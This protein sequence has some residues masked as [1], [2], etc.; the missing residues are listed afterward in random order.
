M[1]PT[2]GTAPDRTALLEI[3][4]R[5]GGLFSAEQALEAGYSPPLIHHHTKRKTFERVRR[6]IYRVVGYPPHEYEEFIAL[7]LWS[8]QS[9]IFSHA[10]ALELHRLSD[11]LPSHIHMTVPTSWKHRRVKVPQGLVLHYDDIPAADQEWHDC[12]LVT[13]VGRT[14]MDC[15]DEHYRTDLLEQ[16]LEQAVHRGLL[17]PRCIIELSPRFPQLGQIDNDSNS[18]ARGIL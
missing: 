16:A 12:V 2:R 1:I 11:A 9:G 6:G 17:S 4:S 7:S 15:D 13:S 5:Q 10:T 3:V 18:A 8:K 14:L